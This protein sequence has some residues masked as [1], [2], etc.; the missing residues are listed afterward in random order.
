[1]LPRH[2]YIPIGTHKKQLAKSSNKLQIALG[3][4]GPFQ[5]LG[6]LIHAKGVLNKP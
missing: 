5:C 4:F 1:V 3:G 2:Y 6:W